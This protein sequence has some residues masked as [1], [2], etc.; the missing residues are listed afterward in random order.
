MIYSNEGNLP[1]LAL[2]P[3]VSITLE[4]GEKEYRA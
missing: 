2:F 1:L 4:A 3:E